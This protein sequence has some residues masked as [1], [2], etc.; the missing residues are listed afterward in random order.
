MIDRVDQLTVKLPWFF[1]AYKKKHRIK[2][3]FA[4]RSI[5][6]AVGGNIEA[7]VIFEF[8]KKNKYRHVEIDMDITER[9]QPLERNLTTSSRPQSTQKFA[10]AP[11][12]VEFQSL[13]IDDMNTV[14]NQSL[15][16]KHTMVPTEENKQPRSFQLN[17]HL[18][19]EYDQ[20][21]NE[22][23]FHNLVIANMGLVQSIA[24]RYKNYMNHN[25]SEE[26]LVQEGI[27]G[28]MKA[29]KRYDNNKGDALSTYATYWIRQ[30]IIRAIIDKGTTVRIPVHM[31]EQIRKLKKMEA[32]LAVGIEE[33][34][35]LTELC[36]VLGIT[37]KKYHELKQVEYSFLAFTSLNQYVSKEGEDTELLDFIPNDRLE[38][39]A[40]MPVDFKDP[41][42][43]TERS[44]LNKNIR[45]LLDRLT[46]RER[47]VLQY[48][49][50][51]LDGRQRTLEEIGQMMGV[52][53]E[54]IRQI[55]AKAL[56]RLQAVK[57]RQR[58]IWNI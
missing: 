18:L 17:E 58:W 1:E 56:R 24:A 37:E 15:H 16:P 12:K 25:M 34:H 26:D 53:R 11:S 19:S 48:R 50:G 45:I 22:I 3:S 57:N 41:Y 23:I 55:E 46:E 4:H 6:K 7:K 33:D 21:K 2:L 10:E 47:D 13:E 49:F 31:I 44:L 42:E 40:S 54:R 51:L 36:E 9:Q 43:L 39:L 30:T 38:I 5:V 20:S 29:I 35:S 52:T 14:L 32:E 8:L 27:F 28:L